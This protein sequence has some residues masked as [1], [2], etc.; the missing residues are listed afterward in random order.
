MALDLDKIR[1]TAVRVAASHGLD[2]V[3]LEFLGSAK[4]RILRVYIEK[5]AAH[6]AALAVEGGEI[7]LPA[8]VGADQLAGITVEDC[9]QFSQD[10]GTV[11]D[12]NDLI[13]GG[14][15][16]LEVSSPGLDRK[17]RTRG[18]FERFSGSLVKLRTASAVDGNSHWQGRLTA[19]TADAITLELPAPK[20]KKGKPSAAAAGTVTIALSNIVKANLEPEF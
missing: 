12:I 2:V 10:F 13:P 19:V 1:E 11:L 9:E 8:G 3:D 6:R 7:A 5:D 4:H 18:D 15:Y 20:A 17:L 14:E 16:S